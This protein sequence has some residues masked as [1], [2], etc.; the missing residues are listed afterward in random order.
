MERWNPVLCRSFPRP[1]LAVSEP[2]ARHYT[3]ARLPRIRQGIR[4]SENRFILH[5]SALKGH[6]KGR[7]ALLFKR[8]S[9]ILVALAGIYFYSGL[10][11][12]RSNGLVAAQN[13]VSDPPSQ[14]IAD[15]SFQPYMD[16]KL[17]HFLG[18]LW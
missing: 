1:F 4:T 14:T 10:C 5:G 8:R 3:C 7:P 18:S 16:S 9:L 6:A 11:F 17:R 13:I 15:H 12:C 2:D